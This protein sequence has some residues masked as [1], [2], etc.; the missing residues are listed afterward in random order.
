MVDRLLSMSWSE[1]RGEVGENALCRNR[2]RGLPSSWGRKAGGGRCGRAGWDQGPDVSTFKLGTASLPGEGVRG[3]TALY[4]GGAGDTDM[5]WIG[6]SLELAEHFGQI[7]SASSSLSEG[8]FAWVVSRYIGMSALLKDIGETGK[9]GMARLTESR[10]Q[11]RFL[12][13]LNEKFTEQGESNR[14]AIFGKKT[15]TSPGTV[16]ER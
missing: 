14:S 2:T 5:Q 4:G 9:F 16:G 7:C 10:L 11:L 13:E 1:I 12:K 15:T 6:W 3:V 8:A